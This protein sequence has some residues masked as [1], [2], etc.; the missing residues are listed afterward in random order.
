MASEDVLVLSAAYYASE[1]GCQCLVD[2]AR[3]LDIPLQ[4][5]GIGEPW[6]WWREGKIRRLKQEIKARRR[7][8][9]FVLFVDSYDVFFTKDL[10][11]IERRYH[12]MMAPV[13]VSTQSTPW[14]FG[15]WAERYG[16]ITSSPFKYLNCGS[17]IGEI[18]TMMRL[19]DWL[20]E[21]FPQW[22]SDDQASWTQAYLEHPEFGIQLDTGCQLFQTMSNTECM[23]KKHGGFYNSATDSWPCLMHY[24]GRTTGMQKDFDWWKAQHEAEPRVR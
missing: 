4:L 13:V 3:T 10:E 17:V 20:Y 5:Y 8:H 2:S 15:A 7:Q 9:H 11:T 18:P 19:L 12:A 6:P 1:A 24:N 16:S 14:P 22:D 23:V 21:D